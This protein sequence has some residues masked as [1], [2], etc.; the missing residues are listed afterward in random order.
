MNNFSV[1]HVHS[2]GMK[3]R[4]S[5]DA[6]KKYTQSSEWQE[7]KNQ[8]MRLKIMNLNPIFFPNISKFSKYLQTI[9]HDISI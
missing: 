7:D 9:D 8:K 4:L 2:M 5:C 6:V 3:F 1:V